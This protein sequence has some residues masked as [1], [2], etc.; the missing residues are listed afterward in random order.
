M[1]SRSWLP[2]QGAVRDI[3]GDRGKP[4]VGYP[5][6]RNFGVQRLPA[7]APDV[8]RVLEGW[9][10]DGWSDDDLLALESVR[11]TVRDWVVKAAPRNVNV[12]RRLLRTTATLTVWAY[13]TWGTADVAVVLD[14]RNV[15]H[16]VMGI[17]SH[18]SQT[19]RENTRGALR[20]V[21]R[22]AYPAGWPAPPPQVGRTTTAAP[23]DSIDETAFVRAAKLAGRFN[24]A[25]RLW[26]VGG[27]FGG[28]LYGREL[29]LARVDDLEEVSGRRLIV[30]T[31]GSKA[32]LVPIRHAHTEVVREALDHAH[33]GRFIKTTGA[34]QRL[35]DQ[36]S[37]GFRRRRGTVSK[38]GPV[39]LAAS[40]PGRR[41]ITRCPAVAGRPHIGY[42]SGGP[43]PRSSQPS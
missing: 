14:P 19:W 28:G 32:R 30:R 39:D 10:P 21:G 31:K 38:E 35:P 42:H 23:Y 18:R 29:A 27:S 24:R 2:D 41:D 8:T 3:R 9:C 5:S 12:A 25:G 15:E 33:N 20:T 13:R 4:V 17:N 43:S 26:V 6:E 11:E 22:A 40:P 36:Q 16:W 1:R 37:S 7:L 34:E